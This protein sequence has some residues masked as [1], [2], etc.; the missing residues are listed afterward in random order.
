MFHRIDYKNQT[1]PILLSK[2]VSNYDKL[3]KVNE[4]TCQRIQ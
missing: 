4:R 1:K 2:G 3:Q